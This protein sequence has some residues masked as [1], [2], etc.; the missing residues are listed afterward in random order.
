MNA[1]WGNK[2]KKPCV[3]IKIVQSNMLHMALATPNG[4]TFSRSGFVLSLEL[5]FAQQFSR[6]GK[7]LQNGDKVWT[8]GKKNWV[9]LFFKAATSA[10]EVNF[11]FSFWSNLA[12]LFAA[13]LKKA[14]FFFVFKVSTDHLFDNLESEKRNNCFGKK[15]GKRLGFWIQKSARTLVDRLLAVCLSL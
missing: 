15:S 7:R 5:L 13:Y 12:R 14:F 10:L 11:C 9:F 6:P 3:E 8:N 2:E 4:Q 1:K